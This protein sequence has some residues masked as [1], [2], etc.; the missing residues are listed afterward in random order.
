MS[1]RSIV[2]KNRYIV[3]DHLRAGLEFPDLVIKLSGGQTRALK[4]EAGQFVPVELLDERDVALSEHSGCIFRALRAGWIINPDAP[5]QPKEEK[6]E[7]KKESSQP[8]QN[9]KL[10]ETISP[11]DFAK[12]RDKSGTVTIINA[13]GPQPAVQVE[14]MRFNGSMPVQNDERAVGTTKEGT[15][16]VMSPETRKDPDAAVD[17]AK[18]QEVVKV[19]G[20]LPTNFLEFAKLTHFAKL[21]V[22]K[23]TNSITLLKEIVAQ[24]EVKQLVNNANG[25]L[26]ELETPA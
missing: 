11:E 16:V 8:K 3:A 7:A 19:G 18:I 6:V 14:V 2:T 23:L 24:S 20:G 10:V 12:M 21:D 22:I 5:V 1:R 15:S 13:S 25:R 26:R 17:I 9:Y 4:V